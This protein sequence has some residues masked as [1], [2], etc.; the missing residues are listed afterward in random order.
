MVDNA[1]I[2]IILQ[3]VCNV[4][5]LDCNAAKE[6]IHNFIKEKNGKLILEESRGVKELGY[7][8]KKQ[9]RGVDYLIKQLSQGGA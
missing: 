5:C 6:K 2:I 7:P 1:N 4:H 9:K 3:Q 8:V